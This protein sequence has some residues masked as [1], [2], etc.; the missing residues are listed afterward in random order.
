MLWIEST[1][2]SHSWAW[3]RH[4]S[5]RPRLA[6][7]AEP[8]SPIV[9]FISLPACAFLTRRMSTPLHAAVTSRI[10]VSMATA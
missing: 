6:D 2:L 8:H 4:S 7:T 9:Q 1:Q 10:A 5:P 3:D